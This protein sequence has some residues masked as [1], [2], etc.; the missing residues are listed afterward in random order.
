MDACACGVL[1]LYLWLIVARPWQLCCVLSGVWI[2]CDISPIIHRAPLITIYSRPDSRNLFSAT[3]V[4]SISTFVFDF[5]NLPIV[6]ARF[7]LED[8]PIVTNQIAYTIYIY[9]RKVA[10]HS[11]RDPSI[12]SQ[13]RSV[14][15]IGANEESEI[16]RICPLHYLRISYESRIANIR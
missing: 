2:V 14:W 6:C 1:L 16:R 12:S 11:T 4:L 15:R 7:D 5:E 9:V 13:N 3:K 8:L 10:S